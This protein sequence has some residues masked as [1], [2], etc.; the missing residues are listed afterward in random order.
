MLFDIY[1]TLCVTGEFD[2][3]F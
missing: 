1:G 3:R 2:A